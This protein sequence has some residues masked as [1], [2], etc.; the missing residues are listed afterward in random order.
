MTLELNGKSVVMEVD[1]RAAVSLMSETSQKKLFPQ[2]NIQKT[3]MKLQ[4][5]TVEALSVLGTFE[6]Q[7]KYGNYVGNL[8]LF[9]VSGNGPTLFGR[10]WL[11]DIRLDWS[12]LGVANAQLKPLTFKGLLTTYSD[13][14]KEELGTSL[15]LSLV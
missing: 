8:I 2:A 15:R 6:V 9:V 4:T 12:S 14:F 7:V 13:V 1:M 10:D 3:T 11:I 5:Y